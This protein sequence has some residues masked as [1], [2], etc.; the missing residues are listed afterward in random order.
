MRPIRPDM[1]AV[2][3]SQGD[4]PIFVGRKSGQSP[5]DMAAV[6]R[7]PT[8]Y[9]RRRGGLLLLLSIGLLSTGCRPDEA[10]PPQSAAAPETSGARAA[11][12]V[13]SSPAAAARGD[14]WPL[15]RGDSQATGVPTGACPSDSNCS[16]RSRR[17][18]GS[19][20]RPPSSTKA[21]SSSARPKAVCTPSIWP[22]ASGVGRC[23]PTWAFGLGGGPQ[24]AG[25]HRRPRR[26][27]LLRQRPLGHGEV[28]L[29]GGRRNQTPAPTSAAIGYCSARRTPTSI[30]CRRRRASCCGSSRPRTRSGLSPAC[31]T[32]GSIS[33]AATGSSTSSISATASDWPRSTSM[34]SAVRPPPCWQTPPLSGPRRTGSWPSAAWAAAGPF[35]TTRTGPIPRRSGRRRP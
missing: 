13:S 32:S 3:V 26:P 10:T 16:G 35:G 15:F 28:E 21:P 29:S 1:A 22:T 20:S 34:G 11:E 23:R 18:R 31:A 27:L 4:S 17:T 6:R 14:A 9:A 30:A 19:S 12:P 7:L 25:L 8:A 33:A 5:G 2:R 24:R